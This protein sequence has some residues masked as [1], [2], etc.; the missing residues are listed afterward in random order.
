MLQ[1]ISLNK[2]CSKINFQIK[3]EDYNHYDYIFG[4]DDQNILDLKS[5]APK[6]YS[7][8]ILLLGDFDPEGERI[9]RD[10]YYVMKFFAKF[11]VF[12]WVS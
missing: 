7:A 5:K 1:L 6:E 10:P 8:K 9:I 11:L 2:L 4:M 3:Q 12:V